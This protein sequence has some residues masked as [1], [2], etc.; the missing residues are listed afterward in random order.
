MRMDS[1]AV[2]AFRIVRSF[3][4]ICRSISKKD[5]I[6]SCQNQTCLCVS[7][8]SWQHRQ[9]RSLYSFSRYSSNMASL[10]SKCMQKVVTGT[11]SFTIVSCTTWNM[12]KNSFLMMYR[13]VQAKSC[14]A[15]LQLR[16]LFYF[17]A[18][19]CSA[20]DSQL[21]PDTPWCAVLTLHIDRLKSLADAF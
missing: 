15:Q 16:L 2:L 13:Q 11:P 17:T 3:Y 14:M 1:P 5:Q 21:L 9:Y 18:L 20:R 6:P 7:T 19:Q 8:G 12:D 10:V 4:R